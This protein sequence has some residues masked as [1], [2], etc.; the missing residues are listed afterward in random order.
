MRLWRTSSWNLGSAAEK[1][2]SM[3][4]MADPS[5][6]EFDDTRAARRAGI[7]A[8]FGA[9]GA[10]LGASFIGFGTLARSSGFDLGQSM[11]TS[12]FIWALPGQIALA[13]LVATGAGLA[14][15]ATKFPA[16]IVALERCGGALIVLSLALLGGSLPFLS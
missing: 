11:A 15:A 5:G 7:R 13:E 9:P 10:V 16:H 1:I 2:E 3:S 12:G 14:F 6:E 4:E 8:G